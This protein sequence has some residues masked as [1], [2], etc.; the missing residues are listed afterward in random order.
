ME[1][2]AIVLLC[3]M[4]CTSTQCMLS[5]CSGVQNVALI[6]VSCLRGG[7]C[8]LLMI[9]F[10]CKMHIASTAYTSQEIWAVGQ[11][12]PAALM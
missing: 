2:V 4:V 7:L 8:E 9:L 10:E 1:Q 3:C 5:M 11:H 12:Y 6:R